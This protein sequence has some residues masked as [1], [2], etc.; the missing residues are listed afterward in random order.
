MSYRKLSPSEIKIKELVSDNLKTYY[1]YQLN[2]YDLSDEIRSFSTSLIRTSNDKHYSKPDSNFL[3][4]ILERDEH[5]YFCKR[6]SKYL[7]MLKD[8]SKE[9]YSVITLKFQFNYTVSDISDELCRDSTVISYM[10]NKA[11]LLLAVFDTNIDYSVDNYIE[12]L[13]NH[14]KNYQIKERVKIL[15]VQKEDDT[16]K[17]LNKIS[18]I[19]VSDSYKD[20]SL[21]IFTNDIEVSREVLK[22]VYTFA[23]LHPN[24]NLDMENFKTKA[25]QMRLTNKEIRSIQK[26][27]IK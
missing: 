15:C 14:S 19:F 6:Y 2:H 1:D 9:L 26:S 24:I 7:D 20:V 22:I 13:D 17:V 3:T 8:Y 18:E 25:Q 27:K 11:A 21:S 10:S 12:Y 16:E 23:F 5:E 4:V